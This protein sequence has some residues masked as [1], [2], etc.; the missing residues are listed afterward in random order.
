MKYFFFLCFSFLFLHTSVQ[1]QANREYLIASQLIR[2]QDYERAKQLLEELVKKEPT[3][4]VYLQQLVICYTSLKEYEN[5]IDLLSKSSSKTK[6]NYNLENDFANLTYLTG[7][8]LKAFDLWETLLK[9]NNRNL[10]AYQLI[11][12]TLVERREFARAALM[13]KQAR[14]VFKNSFLFLN[15]LANAF[16]QSNNYGEAAKELIGIVENNPG[17]LDLVQ[18]QFTRF[19]DDLLFDEAILSLEEANLEKTSTKETVT[20]AKRELLLWLYLERNVD[21]RA[22]SWAMMLERKY[23]TDYFVFNVAQNLIKKE[24]FELADEA[25]NFYLQKGQEGMRA[26]AFEAKAN[27]YLKWAKKSDEEGLSIFGKSDSLVVEAAQLL[28]KVVQDFPDFDAKV[29]V[30]LKLIDIYLTQLGAVDKARSAYKTVLSTYDNQ[31]NVDDRAFLLGRFAMLDGDFRMAR[32]ELTKANKS[33]RGAEMLEKSRYFLALNDFYAGDFEFA[34]I[35]L[36]SVERQPT[37]FY[38]NDAVQLRNW[39]RKGTQKDSVLPELV[40]F[41]KAMFAKSRTEDKASFDILSSNF[42][43]LN[44]LQDEAAKILVDFYR[45]KDPI[46]AYKWLKS[47]KDL[48]LNEELYFEYVSLGYVLVQKKEV[49]ISKSQSETDL[50]SFLKQYPSGFFATKVRG[51]LQNMMGETL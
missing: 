33:N 30:Y 2:M 35:Q 18:R 4:V 1:A 45:K 48:T 7:D 28:E 46:E 14:V 23:P 29:P 26:I 20:Q 13:Y 25:L 27:L 44:Q 38:A 8:T 41:S 3:N 5:G 47:Y 50:K 10:M 16:V 22:I 42:E 49:S 32:M 12:S 21:K 17:R 31:L 40:I 34:R 6:G 43:T 15:E 36:K 24:S 39:I 19:S 9:E 37:S 11:A 51:L